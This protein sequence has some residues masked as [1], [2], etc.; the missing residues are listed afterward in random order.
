MTANRPVSTVLYATDLVSR[1]RA[2]ENDAFDELYTRYSPRIFGFLVQRLNGDVEEA[3]D[4]TADVFAKV[5]QKIDGFQERGAPLSSWLFSIAHNRL[6]D[7]VRRR[8]RQPQVALED[9]PQLTGGPV[10]QQVDQQ[11]AMTQI[12]AGL[13]LLTRE[14]RQVIV[15]R[16]LES[17]SVSETAVAMNRN[18]EAVKKL[19]ARGLASLRRGMDCLSGCW[20]L[21][22][23]AAV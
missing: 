22:L 20:K 7:A 17:K 11:V 12:E 19:Q 16:F 14:Q 21:N 2:G 10:F 8:P 23:E 9:A 18:E 4:L 13:A 15:L 5:Y 6:I 3:Q 1:I